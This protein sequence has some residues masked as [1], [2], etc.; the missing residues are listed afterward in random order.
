MLP[1][2]FNDT[3]CESISNDSR[4]DSME[5]KE[6]KAIYQRFHAEIESRRDRYYE[7]LALRYS[8]RK[9]HQSTN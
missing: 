1:R 4:V 8:I 5:A 3:E 6:L 9:T 2:T 7:G